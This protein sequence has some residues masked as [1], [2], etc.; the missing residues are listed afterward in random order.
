MHQEPR[1]KDSILLSTQAHASRSFSPL[2]SS[3]LHSYLS[4]ASIYD[5]IFAGNLVPIFYFDFRSF[6]LISSH[7]ISF[8][9][10]LFSTKKSCDSYLP[11]TPIVLFILFILSPI[12]V[13]PLA[14]KAHIKYGVLQLIQERFPHQSSSAWR[15]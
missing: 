6:H 3:I 9:L 1:I 8:S 12:P 4:G 7:F 2:V 14:I 13:V 10:L 15:L 5:E 11:R